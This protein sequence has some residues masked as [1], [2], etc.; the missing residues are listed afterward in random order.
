MKRAGIGANPT[1]FATVLPESEELSMH[2]IFFRFW[3]LWLLFGP[4]SASALDI[5]EIQVQS[6]L[7]QLFDARIPLPT[8]TPEELAK[9]SVKLA[10]PP[11]FNEFGLERASALA[12]LVFSIE[13]NAEGQVY[14]RVVSTKPI[15]E[16]SLALL[17]EFG[18]PRGKTFREFTVFL[19]PVQ[20]LAKRPGDRSKTVMEPPSVVAAPTVTAAILETESSAPPEDGVATDPASVMR[21]AALELAPNPVDSPPEPVRIYRPGDT[22]GPVASGEGLWG[23]ALKVRPDPGVSRDQMMQALFQANPQAFGKSGISGL[24]TGAVLRIP[25]LQEIADFTGS[26]VAR[27]L[28]AAA[29][30]VKAGA[31][32]NPAPV[33]PELAVAEKASLDSPEVF[34]LPPSD[35]PE[36][37]AVVPVASDSPT[38][39]APASV[40][41]VQPKSEPVAVTV[42]SASASPTLEPSVLPVA[43]VSEP[44]SMTPL[45]SLVVAEMIAKVIPVPSMALAWTTVGGPPVS[46]RASSA[47][48]L[49]IAA[50]PLPVVEAM[51][52]SP[53]PKPPLTPIDGFALLTE[54][55]QRMPLS[56]FELLPP[57]QRIDRPVTMPVAPTDQPHQPTPKPAPVDGFVLLTEI[58]QRM[59]L[60]V[61]ELLPPMQRID[62]SVTT[63]VAPTEQPHQP[64]PTPTPVD[65]F[66]LLTEIEQRMPLSVFELLPPMQRTDRSVTT[67]VA[68]TE[69]P[70]SAV[71]PAEPPPSVESATVISSEYG[72][73]IANERLWDIAARTV[74]DP[75]ISKDQM[76]RALFKANPQAFSKPGNMDSLK[77]GAVL[78]I[79]T[80]REIAEHTGSRVAK[81]LLE[82]QRQAVTDSATS[83]PTAPTRPL[84]SETLPSH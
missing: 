24:K 56:V 68:P 2:R 58:E 50:V 22:Y 82:Q 33:A 41:P 7:N 9:V 30:A 63:P 10:P 64:T 51:T 62:R 65:G 27:Q 75:G 28:A 43:A 55:E 19:D 76:M 25:T 34:P 79:P 83:E 26:P 36:P 80:L 61:F 18:W 71:Q 21:A 72:P 40:E 45:L 16:P 15:R 20:R 12:N 4:M 78:R 81:Q 3:L 60:S 42:S 52:L 35:L 6:A 39:A 14:V 53:P 1:G 38:P 29:P 74:P 47:P 31:D 66:A 17:L 46:G 69:Q 49:E 44:V 37:T 67:P 84:T 54:I 11:M 48:A 32:P 13:Y 5:G 8:L 23:I 59:P 73:V 77:L 70:A 57:M